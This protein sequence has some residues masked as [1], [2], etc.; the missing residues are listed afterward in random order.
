MNDAPNNRSTDI[1]PDRN[2]EEILGAVDRELSRSA[3][4]RYLA[5][6]LASLVVTALTGAL[7]ATE[8]GLPFRTHVAFAGIV[9]LGIAWMTVATY[10]LTRRQ[11]LYAADQVLAT[12]LAL[13]ASSAVGIATTILVGVRGGVLPA[14]AAAGMALMFVTTSTVLH[15]AAR[16][17][18]DAL[19]THRRELLK[20]L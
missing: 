9:V 8:P 19:L 17:R 3:R 7:W 5:V 11:P 2:T 12:G 16:R 13:V 1:G 14:L 6:G 20:T 4:L 10:V 18:R 15:L